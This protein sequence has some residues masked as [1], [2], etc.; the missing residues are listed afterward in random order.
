MLV[1]LRNARTTVPILTVEGPQASDVIDEIAELTTG[2]SLHGGEAKAMFNLL[3][4]QLSGRGDIDGWSFTGEWP[5]RGEEFGVITVVEDD[6]NHDLAFGRLCGDCGRLQFAS[7]GA[8][9]RDYHGRW[10]SGPGCSVAELGAVEGQVSADVAAH[11]RMVI[12]DELAAAETEAERMAVLQHLNSRGPASTEALHD[13]QPS[14]GGVWSKER[15]QLHE[16]IL[17]AELASAAHVPR[18]HRAIML[19]GLPGSGKSSALKNP[20]LGIPFDG[21]NPRDFYH[22]DSDHLKQVLLDRGAVERVPGMTD[23]EHA[24]LVHQES[25]YLSDTMHA[26]VTAEGINVIVDRTMGWPPDDELARLRANGYSVRGIFVDVPIDEAIVSTHRRWTQGGRFIPPS[27]LDDS[28]VEGATSKNRQTFDRIKDQFDD[29]AL[30]DNS[31]IDKREPKGTVTTGDGKYSFA[32]DGLRVHFGYE[33]VPR[34]P[35]GKWT[36]GS[37]STSAGDAGEFDDALYSFAD[38]QGGYE[39]HRT[40]DEAYAKLVKEAPAEDVVHLDTY[41]GEGHININRHL[42]GKEL[43]PSNKDYDP[44][45]DTSADNVEERVAGMDRLLADHGVPVPEKLLFRGKNDRTSSLEEMDWNVGDE[46]TDKGFG[47]WSADATGDASEF[48]TGLGSTKAK[49]GVM[50]RLTNAKGVN[51]VPGEQREG[52]W[53]LD[54]GTEYRVTDITEHTFDGKHFRFIDLERTGG[55]TASASFTTSESARRA[56]QTRK[57][58]LPP[59]EDQPGPTSMSHTGDSLLGD[60]PGGDQLAA[61]DHIGGPLGSQ[62]GGWYR[63]KETGQRY[64]VKPAQS[65]RHAE[66]EYAAAKFYKRA[67]LNVDDTGVFA[68]ADGKWF[69]VKRAIQGSDGKLGKIIGDDITPDLQRQARDGFGVDAVAASWDAYGMNGDNVIVDQSGQLHRID[70]G[71]SFAYRAMGSDK[72]SFNPGVPWTEPETLR[73]GRQG[74]ALYGPITDQQAGASLARLRSIDLDAYAADLDAAGVSPTMRDRIVTTL[75]D[76]IDV[77]LPGIL[78]ELDYNPNLSASAAF[79]VETVKRDYHGRWTSGAAGG[80][81]HID[82]VGDV[83]AY[84]AAH[85]QE[86]G[87]PIFV[88]HGRLVDG[89]DPVAKHALLFHIRERVAP[90]AYIADGMARFRAEHGLTEPQVDIATIPA[91]QLKSHV[92]ARV[93]ETTPDQSNDPKVRAAYAEFHR[94]SELMYDFMTRPEADGGLGV[95]VE[96]WTNDDPAHFGEG[97]YPNA[98]AQADDLRDNHHIFLESG[99][100]GEHS[101]LSR[102]QYDRF[103]A[104]HDV[105]GHGG[106]GSGF[107]RHGEYEAY[108]AHS[109]MY[110]GEGR[111][112]MAS[113][114]HGVNSASWSGMPGTPGT[115]KSVLLPEALI[116]DPWDSSGHLVPV[117]GP[118]VLAKYLPAHEELPLV[119]S[120]ALS[121]EATAD[122]LHVTAES[123]AAL[124]YL[125]E[126]TGMGS[127]LAQSYDDTPFHNV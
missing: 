79:G 66:N 99:L 96:M 92:V 65:P 113:E 102:D 59:V 13:W 111:Q 71:G 109:S 51:A 63:D 68:N 85:P 89:L 95:T 26:L 30:V 40:V 91:D 9:P 38:G 104:V 10:C 41:I 56:W 72:E 24:A 119:A 18:E 55:L 83:D 75:H 107:D 29:W 126:T 87:E 1:A 108:L 31:G 127:E 52:E 25:T 84:L 22:L 101:T 86:P 78:D 112:A 57:G 106:V 125:A 4:V 47:S 117:P 17:T 20:D 123:A 11:A 69:I 98:T 81:A 36:S 2:S 77:Q 42:K 33:T 90:V 110:W 50:L 53:I 54:R 94:Q 100:G 62:G 34:D 64:L 114:Y 58:E 61:M 6:V 76:R 67:G 46:I 8:V 122:A 14:P 124:A 19:G 70:V 118:D 82:G 116:A 37:G 103:R 45:Y 49:A 115:G 97:P 7:G 93:F 5:D 73:S 80:G 44:K 105:F 15:T 23:G 32:L 121:E 60:L 12:A 21:D 39:T 27:Y 88:Y 16:Q 28:R 35:D 74:K 48:M 3:T 43:A 120:A